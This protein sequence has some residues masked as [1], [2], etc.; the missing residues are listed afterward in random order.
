MQTNIVVCP[1]CRHV[2]AVGAGL[3]ATCLAAIPEGERTVAGTNLDLHPLAHRKCVEMPVLV[4][5]G[6]EGTALIASI[7]NLYA[8]QINALGAAATTPSAK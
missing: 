8:E 2:I 3:P 6:L 4:P 1:D 7:E 5:D